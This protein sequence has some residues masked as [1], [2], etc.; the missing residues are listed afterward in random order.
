[1]KKALPIL[2]F[3]F[4]QLAALSNTQ[5]NKSA[6]NDTIG[7][8]PFRIQTFSGKVIDQKQVIL[9]WLTAETWA[10]VTHYDVFRSTDNKEFTKVGQV[11]QTNSSVS[12]GQSYT[13]TDNVF[14]ITSNVMY[15]RL[16]QVNKDGLQVWSDILVVRLQAKSKTSVAVWPTP[17]TDEVNISFYKKANGMVVCNYFSTDGKMIHQEK[18]KC[19][20]GIINTK[21]TAIRNWKTGNYFLQLSDETGIIETKQFVKN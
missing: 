18:I 7:G 13:F 16:K 1:M 6:Y 4:A 12:T 10:T 14:N 17:A 9:D 2:V 3:L 15:Y 21:L 5:Q 19:S 20:A 8:L 11:M